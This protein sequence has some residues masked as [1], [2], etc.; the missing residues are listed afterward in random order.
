MNPVALSFY[1]NILKKT[2]TK[3]LD[4]DAMT[5]AAALAYYT[6]LSLAPM[7]LVI[8]FTATRFYSKAEVESAL[9]GEIGTLVGQD[10]ALEISKALDNFEVFSPSIWATILGIGILVFTATTVFITMQNALNKIF[11]VKPKPAGM[12]ILKLIKDR[13][14]SF[15]ILIGI[16]FIMLVSLSVNAVITA[17]SRRLEDLLGGVS[18]VLTEMASLILPLI[19]ITLLFAMIF[20]ILP[21]AK[22][23]WRDTWIGAGVTAGLF[24]VGRYLIGVYIG[25]SNVAGLYDTAGSIMVVMVWVFYAS[26]IVLFGAVFTYVYAD[27]MSSG[28]QPSD[29]AVRVEQ[30]EIVME[31]GV[32]TTN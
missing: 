12:G 25:N 7:L 1:W 26:V 19:I 17:L 22:M 10:A 32:Q 4:D 24:T 29:Y 31:E 11:K 9:F 14:L 21:D 27:A 15:S 8:I 5:H 23:K 3:F 6:V 30:K 28:I 13:F 18:L 16:A 20:K 2:I